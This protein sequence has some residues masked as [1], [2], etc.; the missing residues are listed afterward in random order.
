M[1][2]SDI[3]KQIEKEAEAEVARLNKERDEAIYKIQKEYEKKREAQTEEISARVENGKNKIQRRAETFANM[4]IKNNLLTEKRALLDEA[5]TKSVKALVDSDKYVEILTMLMKKA[6]TE[7]NDGTIIAAKGK[8]DATK[9]ALEASGT[10][11]EF[12]GE[13]MDIEGGFV[14]KSDKVEVDFSFNSILRKEL[15]GELEM[16]LSQLLF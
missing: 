5:F 12:K 2:I 1:A 8:E 7:F 11:F 9:K 6:S 13:A 15:W 16:E 10:S 4:E 14:L 3:T